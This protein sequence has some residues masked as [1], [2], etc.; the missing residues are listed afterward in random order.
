MKV[1]SLISILRCVRISKIVQMLS[2]GLGLLL[3]CLPA[4]SQLNLGSIA[5]TIT[6]SRAL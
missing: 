2:L 1:A 6:D 4:F 5:G 3:F